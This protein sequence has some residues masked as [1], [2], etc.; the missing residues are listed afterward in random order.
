MNP[1]LYT[2]AI[3]N[4]LSPLKAQWIPD[5]VIAVSE[6]GIIE[7]IGARAKLPARFSHVRARDFPHH[8][9]APGFVDLHTHLPQ[10]R[11]RGMFPSSRRANRQ[12]DLLNWL[13]DIVYPEE[14]RLQRTEYARTIA[15]DFFREL[16]RCGTTTAMVFGSS[17]TEATN[18]A[19]K[20]AER[21]KLRI[22]MG[23]TLMDRNVPKALRE[24]AASAL[25]ATEDLIHRWHRKTSRLWYAV[26]P[27]FA[28]SCSMP[29]L[30]GCAELASQHDTFIQTHINESIK[31]IDLVKKLFP[32]H[33][34]YT[35]VYDKAGLLTSKTILAHCIH[36]SE[37]E[38]ARCKQKDVGIAHC[39]DSNLFL[40]SGQFPIEKFQKARFRFGLGSDIGAGTS[41]SMFRMMRAMSAVQRSALPPTEVFYYATLGGA[42]SL[43]LDPIIGSFGIG[44]AFDAVI[45]DARGTA[46][47][48]ALHQHTSSEAAS[49]YVYRASASDVEGVFV[50]GEQLK[51]SRS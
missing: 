1:T 16:Q 7:F 29:L 32:T 27:R 38:L 50:Q 45:V 13:E 51:R 15:R 10:L 28:V 19:F 11:C 25:R 2:G 21:S 9:I 14:Q 30:K 47:G 40:G 49:L 35:D 22:I 8:I 48:K 24:H 3:L 41:L 31:E 26:T 43:S 34:S 6:K 18:G 44:K 42:R 39:P 12:I 33:R 23:K 20:E 46:S 17:F 5:G 37:K 36:A 4:P